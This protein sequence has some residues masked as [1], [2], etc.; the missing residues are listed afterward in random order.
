[1]FTRLFALLLLVTGF[2]SVQAQEHSSVR[3]SEI[4]VNNESGRV[5]DCGMHSS[6]I[7]IFNNGNVPVNIGGCY[8]TDDLSNPTKFWISKGDERATKLEAKGCLLFWAD[9]KPQHGIFHVNFELKNAQTVALF[10]PT[11]TKLID[12]IVIEQPQKADVSYGRLDMVGEECSFLAASTPGTV[13]DLSK[14]EA[15][16]VQSKEINT[17]SLHGMVKGILIVFLVI[18]VVYVVYLLRKKKFVQSTASVEEESV[19]ST[20]YANEAYDEV[21]AAI[22]LALHLYQNDLHD[23]ENTVLTMRKVSRTYSPW[24][25]KIY[26]LRRLPR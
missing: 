9:G 19:D 5:D 25:S 10:D 15:A 14:K 23:F 21:S 18:A 24:S 8:L 2:V 13:N 6:W 11:G 1:M 7:E 26:T 20:V 16:T 4:L 12:K 17:S 22:S 3:I